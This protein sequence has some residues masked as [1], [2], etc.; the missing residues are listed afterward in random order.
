[1]ISEM[2]QGRQELGSREYSEVTKVAE[3]I[4]KELEEISNDQQ[5]LAKRN[6]QI[7]QSV[8]DRMKDRLGNPNEFVQKQLDRLAKAA[9]AIERAAPGAQSNPGDAYDNLLRRMD[10]TGKA[11]QANDFGAAQEMVDRALQHYRQVQEDAERRL[12]HAERFGDW[13]GS[14]MEIGKALRQ[15]QKAEPELEA[16]AKDIEELMPDPSELLDQNQKNELNRLSKRQGDLGQ[17]TEGVGQKLDQLGEMLPIVGDGPKE[18]LRDAQNAMKGAQ[19]GLGKGDAP[20]ASSDHRRAM[21]A[22]DQLKESLQQMG[23]QGQQ[24]GGMGVPLPFGGA[25]QGQPNGDEG[26][27]RMNPRERVEIPKPDQFRAPAEFREDIL[28]AA[29]KGTVREYRDAVRRYYE[30][31]IK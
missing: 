12:E 9:S 21:D 25:P 11:L 14:E 31:I 8:L 7:S 16:V 26:R 20:G 18:L 13:F 22:L 29:K 1:M 27:G 17:R 5:A 3:E 6:E 10:D 28:D 15:L 4:W 23:E 24:G 19:Q 2:Q 30:E